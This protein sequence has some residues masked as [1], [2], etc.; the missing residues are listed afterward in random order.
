MYLSQN[1]YFEYTIGIEM[2]EDETKK[3]TN[4]ALYKTAPHAFIFS[5]LILSCLHFYKLSSLIVFSCL[6]LYPSL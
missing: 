4:V 1:I 3:W 2:T 6:Y 5:F